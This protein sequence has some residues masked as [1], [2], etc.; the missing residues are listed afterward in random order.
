MNQQLS[1]HVECLK[2][3]LLSLPATGDNGFEGLIGVALHEITGVPFRLAASGSQFGIDG[4]AVYEGDSICFEGKRY[5]GRVPRTEVLSKIADLLISNNEID[6]WVL[7]ATSQIRTQIADAARE[8]GAKIG[9]LVL[10]LDWSQIDL[11]PFSVVLAMGGARIQEFL[12]SNI[13]DKKVLRE[14]LAALEA[15]KK[16]PDF[17]H[18]ADRIQAQCNEPAMGSPLAQ[19][20]NSDWLSDAFSSRN[21]AKIKFGQPL[22]PGGTGTANVRERNTLTDKLQPFFTT[23]SDNTVVCILGGEGNGKSWVVAQSWLALMH[24]PLMILMSPDGFA[25]ELGQNDVVDILIDKLIKQT[26]DDFIVSTKDRWRRKF[27]QWRGHPST[28]S[29][30]L[31]VVI[32]GINQRPKADWARIIESVGDELSQLG[33]RLI[34]TVRAPYFRDRIKGRLSVPFIEISIPEWTGSERDE[35][36]AD[37]GIKSSELHHAI[38]ATLLNPRLLG[39]A[40]ELLDKADISTFEELSISRL[41][42]EHMRMSERDAITPKPAHQFARQLQTHAQEIMTRVNANQQD[43]LNIFELDIEAVADGRFYQAVEGDPTRCTLVDDGLTLALGFSVIDR[44]RIAQRNGRNIDAELDV[45]IDP[46]ATLDDTAGVILAALTVTVAHENYNLEVAASLI[47]GFAALQNPS[48][49]QFPVF[50]SL[51]KSQPQGFMVAAQ[52]LSLATDYQPNFDWIQSAL[53]VAGGNNR[54]W[55]EMTDKV[56]TWLSVHSLSPERRTFSHPSRDPQEKVQE[57]LENNRKKIESKLQALTLAEREILGSLPLE[58]GDLSSLSRLALLLLAGKPL[59]P[60]ARSLLNW[61]FSNALNSDHLAPYKDF[62]HLVSL[63]RIDWLQTRDV[64]LEV[65]AS[66]HEPGVSTTGKWTLVNIL[67][68]TGLSDDDKEAQLMVE[69]L[70]KDRPHFAGWSLI[71]KYC[72]ADPC[73]PASEQPENVTHTAKQYAAIDVSKLCHS[74][75]QS[76]D[77]NFFDMARPGIARFKSEIAVAKHKE[78]AADVL[79]RAGFSLRQGLF[80]LHEHNSLLTINDARELI[81]NRDKTKAASPVDG[82]SD[83]DAWLIS[84]Y[85]LLLAFPFLSAWEQAETLLTTEEDENI[86]NDLIAL[87]KPLSA[88]DFDIL[89]GIACS[90]DNERKKY[91]LLLLAK[92]TPVRLSRSARTHISALFR[93]ES[94]RVRE[95]VLSVIAQSGDGELLG[96]VAVSDWKA[97]DIET[98]NDFEAWYGSVALLEAAAKGLIAHDQVLD[99][100]SESLYSLAAT[101]LDADAVR[102]IARRIDASI[103]QVIELDDDLVAPEIELQVNSPIS[104]EPSTFSVREQPPETKDFMENMRRL[105]E[106][107]DA[108]EQRQRLNH[109]AFLEF[110]AKL[111]QA[112]ARIILD[113]MSL[114]GFTTVVAADEELAVHWHGL[115]MMVADSKL[116]AVHNLV[117]LLAHALGEKKPG[118]AEELFWRVKDSKPLVQFISGRAGVQLDAMS[119]WAGVRSPVLDDQRLARLDRVGTDHDLSIEVLAALLNDKQELLNDYVEGKLSKE[120]P[121]EISWGIMV[122]GFSDQSEFNDEILKRYEGSAGL[123]GSALKAAKYAYER[124]AWAQHW[125]EKMCHE[126]ENSDFWCDAVLFL[127]IVDG[128]FDVWCSDYAQTG[129]PIQ[130]FGPSIYSKLNNRLT[131]WE[132]HRNKKLFGLDAPASIFLAE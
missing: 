58:E 80:E 28:D 110:K 104:F 98:E 20:A 22:S 132:N 120:E 13:S 86:L 78:F 113:H 44:L 126:D 115:F 24:K 97:S 55:K 85:Q 95:Q 45:V 52:T 30:R 112:K 87:A 131:R 3:G 63:N 61:S 32:D 38:A 9:V 111:T 116:P 51:A 70:T 105:S 129:H 64:L 18:H 119:T 21:R 59:A 54:A 107:N 27:K 103:N 8:L 117:L 77:D 53:I 89:L 83:Q 42:F 31:I 1:Q 114:E 50:A 123:V 7:G 122:A 127:K 71:E 47:K 82:L 37:H 67:R 73:N 41:L 102:D 23:A 90:E 2:M 130:L 76:T 100:I 25:E 128:R 40:L 101:M 46:I 15:V 99:R 81:R 56:H 79:S 35:I 49:A 33:G 11:P 93:S 19:R 91:F 108:F 109:D 12:K 66:L 65:S 92:C 60:F 96:Q 68:A 4:N 34:V 17:A 125:F 36:L 72:A 39:I 5:D 106:S 74:M 57:E 69:E 124:N 88:S 94:Q 14:A 121:S 43:D 29:P 16:S 26:G 118:K 84:Q 48:Q 62:S 10:I 6:I 75:N